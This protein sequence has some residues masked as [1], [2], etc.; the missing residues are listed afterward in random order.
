MCSM[1]EKNTIH[2]TPCHGNHL[3]LCANLSRLTKIIKLC[4]I[5]DIKKNNLNDISLLN[6][7]LHLLHHHNDNDE[8]FEY[9]MNQFD[10]CD[11]ETCS[12]FDRIYR[13]R[14]QMEYE[15]DCLQS[16]INLIG[17]IHCFYLHSHDS[18]S[19]LLMKEMSFLNQSTEVSELKEEKI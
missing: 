14:D 7:F 9:I 2:N 5:D 12:I 13:K 6:D 3:S 15:T 16:Y 18:G 11:F 17:K 4:N 1:Q 19:R 8:S 10:H